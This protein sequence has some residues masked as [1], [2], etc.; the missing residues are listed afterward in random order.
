M[1]PRAAPLPKAEVARLLLGC[2]D[3]LGRVAE[4]SAESM[5]GGHGCAPL[6][7]TKGTGGA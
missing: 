4:D 3:S 6:L 1:S 2:K 5:A 7:T